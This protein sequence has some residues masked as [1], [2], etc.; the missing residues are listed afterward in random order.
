MD[1]GGRTSS[2]PG[3][4][5]LQPSGQA[6]VTGVFPSSLPPPAFIF[7]RRGLT[8]HSQSTA[9]ASLSEFLSLIDS[10]PVRF[11]RGEKGK[12]INFM[13][14]FCFR[15]RRDSHPGPHTLHTVASTVFEVSYQ[16]TGVSGDGCLSVCLSVRRSVG[17]SVGLSVC[18]RP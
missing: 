12:H 16:T 9:R 13:Q 18:L 15:T 14:C 4:G 2:R 11:P 6:M 3:G 5:G 17:L 1:R 7:T 8:Q 10:R